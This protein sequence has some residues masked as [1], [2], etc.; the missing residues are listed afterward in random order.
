M[1]S[2][3]L[4]GEPHPAT[5]KPTPPQKA[6]KRRR[7]GENLGKGVKLGDGDRPIANLDDCFAEWSFDTPC[8]LGAPL[9]VLL[10]SVLWPG[11]RL[12]GTRSL[13]GGLGLPEVSTNSVF[14]PV[15]RLRAVV[16][17]RRSM[18]SPA[19]L[20]R[21]TTPVVRQVPYRNLYPA[22]YKKSSRYP[23]PGKTFT[24]LIFIWILYQYG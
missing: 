13:N 24:A 6:R 11:A 8:A 4:D 5:T 22:F 2:C 1:L 7:D 3:L 16:M 18:S 14:S 21:P 17:S 20:F 23:K 19:I 12:P 15:V 10:S 9:G